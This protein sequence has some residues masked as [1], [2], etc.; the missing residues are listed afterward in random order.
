MASKS[1][2]EAI[3]AS[4][5]FDESGFFSIAPF[6]SRVGEG[7]RDIWA[8]ANENDVTA[9]AT[10]AKERII[11]FEQN[12]FRLLRCGTRITAFVVK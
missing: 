10:H 2:C 7:F 4:E 3:L 12:I 5:F 6:G 11:L 8:E 1:S 9:M